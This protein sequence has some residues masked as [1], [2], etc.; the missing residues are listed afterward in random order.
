LGEAWLL[1][2]GLKWREVSFKHSLCLKCIIERWI[3][4]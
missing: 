4:Y 1:G 2:F 3:C